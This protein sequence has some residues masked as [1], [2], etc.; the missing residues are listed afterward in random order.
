MKFKVGDKVRVVG[1]QEKIDEHNIA[2]SM[3]NIVF[4]KGKTFLVEKGMT[5]V[6]T[7]TLSEDFSCKVDFYGYGETMIR[8]DILELIDSKSEIKE[9]AAETDKYDYEFYAFVKG[10][11]CK[12]VF[13]S[14]RVEQTKDVD[15]DE[16]GKVLFGLFESALFLDKFSNG[17][18]NE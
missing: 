1:E 6:V 12:F 14:D 17:V 2:I 5:G 7:D 3:A 9:E 13:K 4:H 15:L 16:E 8:M 18:E 10:D 11:K